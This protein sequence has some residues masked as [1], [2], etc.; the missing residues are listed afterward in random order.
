M[1]KELREIKRDLREVGMT[2]EEMKED[3]DYKCAMY[4]VTSTVN[5]MVEIEERIQTLKA[6]LV[7]SEN[8]Y[9]AAKK[10][11]E[12]EEQKTSAD[13]AKDNREEDEEISIAPSND[14]SRDLDDNQLNQLGEDDMDDEALANSFG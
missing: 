6:K 8:D 12:E 10:R 13:T 3:E 5:T 1:R 9:T 14:G 11:A 4:D 2:E 7:E